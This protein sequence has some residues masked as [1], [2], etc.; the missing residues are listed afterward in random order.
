MKCENDN[1]NDMMGM[2]TGFLPNDLYIISKI[3]ICFDMNA[4]ASLVY[5]T[6]QSNMK[7]NYLTHKHKKKPSIHHLGVVD[8]MLQS[9]I[10]AF[11]VVKNA[12]VFSLAGKAKMNKKRCI[13][14]F[15]SVRVN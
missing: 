7:L 1:E 11:P 6:K 13:V 9:H 4:P 15:S 10:S 2:H 5:D 14:K 12:L 8:I 3:F